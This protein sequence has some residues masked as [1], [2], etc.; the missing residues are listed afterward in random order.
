MSWSST[1]G[2]RRRCGRSRARSHRGR[3]TGSLCDG[4][5]LGALHADWLC[6]VLDTVPAAPSEPHSSFRLPADEGASHD[7]TEERAELT[8]T[9][10]EPQRVTHS[11]RLSAPLDNLAS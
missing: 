3:G 10:S 11:V 4:D 6:M 8:L 7:S 2:L 5:M 1:G 9:C